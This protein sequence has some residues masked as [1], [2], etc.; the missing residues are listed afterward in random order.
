MVLM[1]SGRAIASSQVRDEY[2]GREWAQKL[3]PPEACQA[4]SFI[5]R[6][7]RLVMCIC[8]AQTGDIAYSAIQP[9]RQLCC[10]RDCSLS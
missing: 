6:Y 9:T 4:L 3:A 10:S 2:S 7:E 1:S 5:W 8:W